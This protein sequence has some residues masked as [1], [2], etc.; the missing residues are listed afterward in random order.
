VRANRGEGRAGG[1]AE[2]GNGQEGQP[3]EQNDPPAALAH[4][5]RWAGT[6]EAINP[7]AAKRVASSAPPAAPARPRRWAGSSGRWSA[8]QWPPCRQDRHTQAG[9]VSRVPRSSPPEKQAAGSWQLRPPCTAAC[10]AWPVKVFHRQTAPHTRLTGSGGGAW[11]R[12]KTPPA[13]PRRRGR[14]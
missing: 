9:L 4:P 8:A 11:R 6:K 7:T 1:P 3:L 12:P 5:N 10:T 14:T 13:C 2:R